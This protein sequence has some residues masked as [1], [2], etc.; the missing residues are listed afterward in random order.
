[1]LTISTFL[2]AFDSADFWTFPFELLKRRGHV[3]GLSLAFIARCVV[4]IQCH[5]LHVTKRNLLEFSVRTLSTLH[6][7]SY[8]Q[9]VQ[10]NFGTAEPT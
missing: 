6:A 9:Y 8:M 3:V 7:V 2:G 10:F 5:L 1:M 4:L